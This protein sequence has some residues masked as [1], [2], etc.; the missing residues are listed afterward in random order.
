[1]NRERRIV[2]FTQTIE[3]EMEPAHDG[4]VVAI[5]RCESMTARHLAS[6]SC[7]S[8]RAAAR[9]GVALGDVRAC[10]R[11]A[12]AAIT[13]LVLAFCADAHAALDLDRR[14]ILE[15]AGAIVVHGI[16]PADLT[17]WGGFARL[18]HFVTLIVAGAINVDD[19]RHLLRGERR[20]HV[21]VSVLA[22]TDEWAAQ[23]VQRARETGSVVA[24]AEAGP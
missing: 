19:W 5:R 4:L 1:M 15:A 24:R 16:T 18:E 3:T 12:H 14:C 7:V 22:A 23:R 13:A 9:K 6:R 8:A 17:A 11:V 2:L 20:R 21:Y 10:S